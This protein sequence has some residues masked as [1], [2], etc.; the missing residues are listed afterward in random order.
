MRPKTYSKRTGF[1]GW[2]RMGQKPKEPTN[3]I[4]AASLTEAAP[5]LLAALKAALEASGCD[6]DLCAYPWHEAARQA[7]AKAEGRGE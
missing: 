6:G 3:T 7:I 2:Q 4:P 5:E 1:R